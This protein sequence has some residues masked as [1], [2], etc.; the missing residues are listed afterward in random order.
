MLRRRQIVSLESLAFVRGQGA[1]EI[2]LNQRILGG[3]D[4]IERTL[5]GEV[6][7]LDGRRLLVVRLA[8]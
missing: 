2:V 6:L 8:E 3:R 7:A 4:L 1:G 5:V